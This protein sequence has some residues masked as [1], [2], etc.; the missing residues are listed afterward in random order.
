M[1]SIE[2]YEIKVFQSLL[3]W[4]GRDMKGFAGLYSDSKHISRLYLA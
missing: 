4:D 2:G 1:R 3:E